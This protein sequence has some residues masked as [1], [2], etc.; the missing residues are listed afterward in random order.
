MSNQQEPD[1]DDLE[2]EDEALARLS[3][4]LPHIVADGD[5]LRAHLLEYAK[6]TNAVYAELLEGGFGETRAQR[7]ASRL[8]DK[9]IIPYGGDD[10]EEV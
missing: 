2:D 6:A 3:V 5:Q 7:M 9:L 10:E 4:G 8:W 1:P